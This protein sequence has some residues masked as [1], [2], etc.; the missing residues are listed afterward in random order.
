MSEQLQKIMHGHS[1]SNLSPNTSPVMVKNEMDIVNHTENNQMDPTGVYFGRTSYWRDLH[2]NNSQEKM[3]LTGRRQ[4]YKNKTCS[5]NKKKLNPQDRT[6]NITVCFNC[7]CR[8]HCSY[9]CLYV[10]SSRN[11]HGVKIEEDFSVLHM[12]LMSQQKRK[13]G[14]DIF[15]S[16][17]LVVHPALFVEQNGINVFWKH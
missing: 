7:G 11:K 16:Q 14:G 1:S 5:T 17:M 2:F 4:G 10:H 13:Y 8:F 12:V 9:D 3:N 6:G 15:L